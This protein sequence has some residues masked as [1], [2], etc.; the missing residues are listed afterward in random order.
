MGS[1]VG[2]AS[3]SPSLSPSPP[4]SPVEEP[5]DGMWRHVVYKSPLRL[6]PWHCNSDNYGLSPS[7]I[8]LD[9]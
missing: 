5:S 2:K 6:M 3:L 1:A 8:L 7:G 9:L 4:P